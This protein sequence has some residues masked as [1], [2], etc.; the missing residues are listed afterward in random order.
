MHTQGMR[1]S[2]PLLIVTPL[3][4]QPNSVH[5]K[6]VSLSEGAS[7]APM[8]LLAKLCHTLYS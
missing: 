5:I 1:Y 8:V 2:S 3:L 6:E 4:P 7:D